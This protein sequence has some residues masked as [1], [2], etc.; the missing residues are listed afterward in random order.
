MQ[1]IVRLNLPVNLLSIRQTARTVKFQ[2]AGQHLLKTIHKTHFA[3]QIPQASV[4]SSSAATGIY[5]MF[6]LL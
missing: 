2:G 4:P 5:L 3:R 6:K 1:F